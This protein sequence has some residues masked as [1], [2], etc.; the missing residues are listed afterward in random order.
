MEAHQDARKSDDLIDTLTIPL[1]RSSKG[2]DLVIDHA[3][4]QVAHGSP[5]SLLS[6]VAFSADRR[7]EVRPVTTGY[8]VVL[9][10]NSQLNGT[11]LS[12]AHRARQ[13]T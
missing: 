5:A 3:G 2:G 4:E 8:G 11:P 1:P 13:V 6:F 9:T 10:D 12:E 7:H